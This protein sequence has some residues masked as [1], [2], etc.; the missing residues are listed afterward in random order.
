MTIGPIDSPDPAA[1]GGPAGPASADTVSADAPPPADRAEDARPAGPSGVP[2]GYRRH[3]VTERFAAVVSVALLIAGLGVVGRWSSD[4]SEHPNGP[5]I[6]Q[7]VLSLATEHANAGNETFYVIGTPHEDQLLISRAYAGHQSQAPQNNGPATDFAKNVIIA[8]S[9]DTGC[10]QASEVHLRADND[11]LTL[12]I[13]L[14]RIPG[15]RPGNLINCAI[16]KPLFVRFEVPRSRLPG[17]PTMFDNKHAARV[18]ETPGP[19]VDGSEGTGN[20]MGGLVGHD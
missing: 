14:A 4:M 3:S 5:R 10:R 15:E 12:D 16:S 11:Q 1:A 9:V 18:D 6:D 13:Q 17:L 7:R 19:T 8:V 2:G 20:I